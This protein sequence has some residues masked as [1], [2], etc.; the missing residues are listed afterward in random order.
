M[1]HLSL[2][3]DHRCVHVCVGRKN[4]T[5]L[6]LMEKLISRQGAG[7]THPVNTVTSTSW[8]VCFTAPIYSLNIVLLSVHQPSLQTGL[9]ARCSSMT[10]PEI[11]SIA[12][13]WEKVLWCK[14]TF[15]SQLMSYGLLHITDQALRGRI[16]EAGDGKLSGEVGGKLAGLRVV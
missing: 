2:P 8:P 16:G 1:A 5:G 9:P 15:I 4:C 6:D 12:T 7:C 3:V 11:I 13:T 14:G 10:M